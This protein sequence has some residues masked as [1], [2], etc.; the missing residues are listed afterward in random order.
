M[1]ALILS[2]IHSNLEA[3][4]AVLSAAPAHDAVW[5][6]GDVVGY[7]ANPNE[8]IE[9]VRGLGHTFVRGNH[10]KACSGLTGV[11][12][13]N[14]IASRAAK[15]TQFVLTEEHTDWLRHLSAGPVM[16]D[17]PQVSCVHGSLIDED[18][19][20]L[21][22][23]DAWRPLSEALTRINF[24]GH[25][26]L[27]GGFATDGEEWFRLTP[28]Y[29]SRDG[30]EEYELPLRD[31]ARYLLNPGSVGQPRDG[32]WRAA[33]AIYD[34]A[35]M[36]LTFYRVPYDVRLAQQRILRAGLPDRLAARLREG[37]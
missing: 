13:F 19:Y 35:A 26:H 1:R 28:Q 7:G 33:F 10:D 4:T 37:R 30:A 29:S 34:D 31:G 9:R 14:P 25:T 8:V 36:L 23:R 15:W 17:G 5:N 16:P 32:D 3:L 21:T 11:E 18:E 20:V 27:Q 2:D 24:F 22:V 6:L 12:D